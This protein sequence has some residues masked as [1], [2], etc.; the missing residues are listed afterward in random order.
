MDLL[1]RRQSGEPSP[2]WA[3]LSIYEV[4][5]DGRDVSLRK[6][7]LFRCPWF[8][9]NIHQVLKGDPDRD[10]HDH[11]AHF[12]SFRLLGDYVEELYHPERLEHRRAGWLVRRHALTPHRIA[13][14][15]RICWR[16]VL[17]RRVF[18]N[19]GFHTDEG[20]VPWQEYEHCQ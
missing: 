16:L 10:L 17:S 11:P 9:L 7:Y 8:S 3:L 4:K 13:G 6:F 18:R 12:W 1:Q 15:S 19:W 5:P 14:V 20:W 2:A